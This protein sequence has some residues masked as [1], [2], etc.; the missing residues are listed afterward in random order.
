ML[1]RQHSDVAA[2]TASATCRSR[3]A[4]PTT[5]TSSST[6]RTSRRII[7][8]SR[9]AMNGTLMAEDLGSRNGLYVDRARKRRSEVALDAEHEL[10]HRRDDA[11]RSHGGARGAGRAADAARLAVLAAA[12]A[13]IAAC[14]R[15]RRSISG[16]ARRRAEGDPLFH[17]AADPHDRRVRLDGR[18]ERVTRVFTGHARF[19]LHFLIVAAGLLALFGLRVRSPRSAH[20]R[21]RGPRSRRAS[22]IV[23]WLFLGGDRASRIC[24][25]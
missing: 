11:A 8:A 15:S 9:A 2:R 3:S 1:S 17:A 25:S 6:I 13:C 18:M 20:S 14:S 16:S 22:Y 7:F 24:S 23:A 19:G 5:T 12:I 10:S 21:G 4:A